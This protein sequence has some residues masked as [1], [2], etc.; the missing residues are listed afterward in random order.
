MAAPQPTPVYVN[1][2]CIGGPSL[3]LT[4]T[5]PRLWM[6]LSLRLP[7]GAREYRVNAEAAEALNAL[8]VEWGVT[9]PAD[10]KTIASWANIEDAVCTIFPT[11]ND[12]IPPAR[13]WTLLNLSAT[14]EH[15][16]KIM[17]E[18]QGCC[19]WFAAW[20]P[21]DDSC[22]VYVSESTDF[23]NEAPILTAD[24]L[25]GFY[26]DYALRG[27]MWYATHYPAAAN[28]ALDALEADVAAPND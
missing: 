7:A 14:G 12:F 15:A 25:I 24:S 9:I 28:R 18:N 2:L 27:A 8:E 11:N 23:E 3:G 22:R 21:G 10:L 4:L 26:A 17:D 5:L 6:F 13:G 19:Y 16:V 1:D 20:R